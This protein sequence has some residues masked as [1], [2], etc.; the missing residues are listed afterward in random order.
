MRDQS[1]LVE[2][3]VRRNGRFAARPACVNP[4]D[5]YKGVSRALWR[6][7]LKEWIGFTLIH[8]DWYSSL[9][10]QDANYLASSEIYAYDRR[11]GVLYQHAAN[12]KGGS[13]KLPEKL[14]G[15]SPRFAK[16]GYR[17]EYEFS[18]DGKR[19]RI[20]LDISASPKAPAST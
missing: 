11:A 8:P 12:A 18:G 10:M 6:L 17:I 14:A 20:R 19:H 9:V 4:L 13:L 1:S 2:G 5:A 3:G 15:A 7:R 16:D